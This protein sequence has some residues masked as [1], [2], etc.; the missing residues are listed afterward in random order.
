MPELIDARTIFVGEPSSEILPDLMSGGGE[1]DACHN[2][3]RN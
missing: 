3:F 1:E 2:L